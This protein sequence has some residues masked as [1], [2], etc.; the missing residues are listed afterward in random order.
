MHDLFYLGLANAAAAVVLAIPAYA[1]G[2]WGKRPAIAHFLWV[3]VLAKLLTPPL[4]KL[5]VKL[6]GAQEHGSVRSLAD[7]GL[8]PSAPTNLE[9]SKSA[10]P[11]GGVAEPPALPVTPS[12]EAAPVA[13][14]P[15]E[16]VS[17]ITWQQVLSFCWIGGSAVIGTLTLWRLGAFLRCLRR[18]RPANDSMQFLTAELAG[19][20]RLK[21]KPNVSIASMRMPPLAWGRGKNARIVVPAELWEKLDHDQRVM[22]L[23]HELAH[24]RRGDHWVRLLEMAAR[25]IYWWHPLV[26]IAGRELRE[27]EE[28][29]CD[30]W[31]IWALPDAAKAYARALMDTVDFLARRNAPLPAGASGIGQ[32]HDL[33]RR[34]IM[35]MR[36]TTPRKLSTAS[37]CGLV[38]LGG[39]AMAVAPGLAEQRSTA[40]NLATFEPQSRSAPADDQDEELARLRQQESSLRQA[41]DAVAR[42]LDQTRKQLRDMQ[43][44]PT[45]LARPA[46]ERTR[47]RNV[48]A[49]EA[50]PL[51]AVPAPPVTLPRTASTPPLAAPVRERI[52]GAQ[53]VEERLG[54][55]EE[56]MSQIA[57]EIQAMRRDMRSGRTPATQPR[58]RPP[59]NTPPNPDFE[60]SAL[61]PLPPPSVAPPGF[62]LQ[63][64]IVNVPPPGVEVPEATT[65]PAIVPVP[66]APVAPAAPAL[67]R[68]RP[69]PPKPESDPTPLGT[70]LPT[71]RPPENAATVRP[72]NP[73]PAPKEPGR[74]D[75]SPSQSN[76]GGR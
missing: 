10:L 61:V 63:P 33:R 73:P 25:T 65:A 68:S 51:A 75:S 76:I 28:Q 1:V 41:M 59:A 15:K 13:T 34:L 37:I 17:A 30:A 2:R 48:Q 39:I 4:W 72:V 58:Q 42:S 57:N 53:P 18:M 38:I 40:E 35:I 71:T 12:L 64:S 43:G 62:V 11:V 6:P 14:L 45:Q 16:D 19:R 21:N 70:P 69:V 44:A 32:V 22:L 24:L 5:P 20:L 54:R 27:A 36:G 3:L 52:R 29:C 50:Q 31:A 49:T 67:R 9:A 74:P 7:D 56:Q 47:S 66:P 8:L 26:W 23:V 55:L 60:P 46:A